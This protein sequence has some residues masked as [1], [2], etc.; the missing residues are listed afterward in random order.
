MGEA[1]I[2]NGRE[3]KYR[4]R[5]PLEEGAT[6]ERVILKCMLNKLGGAMNGTE[7]W[8]VLI[9]TENPSYSI[10]GGEFTK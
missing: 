3:I 9:S 2:T 6:Y 10:N 7:K 8:W 4:G 5:K 1:S